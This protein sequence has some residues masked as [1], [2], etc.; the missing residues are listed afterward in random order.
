MTANRLAAL[1][2]VLL[3]ACSAGSSGMPAPADATAGS[4]TGSTAP[5]APE[6]FTVTVDGR[7]MVGTCTGQAPPGTPTIVLESGMQSDRFQLEPIGGPFES[8]TRVCAYDRAGI[9]GSDPVTELPRPVTAVVE[10]LHAFLQ[11][12]EIAPPY[13]LIGFSMGGTVVTL[14]AQRYPDEVAG[15]VEMNGG[16]DDHGFTEAL[17]GIDFP[18][19]GGLPAQRAYSRGGNDEHV[20]LWAASILD[21]PIAPSIPYTVMYNSA[22]CVKSDTACNEVQPAVERFMDQIVALGS[23]GRRVDV[24]GA[25]HAIWETD[26]DVVLASIEELWAEVTAT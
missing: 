22:S 5:G 8:R 17:D 3:A 10:D 26:L 23:G 24:V 13:F 11:A 2:V 25:N 6:T 9:G 19:R 14:Y 4:P 21:A 18:G 20:D 12:G 1:L 7:E 15:F 16:Y